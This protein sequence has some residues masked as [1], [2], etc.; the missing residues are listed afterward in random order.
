M[1]IKL[2]NKHIVTLIPF[3]QNMKLRG[4]RSRARSKFLEIAMKSYYSLHES[5]VELLKEYAVLDDSGEPKQSENGFTLKEE[6]AREYLVER[7]KLFS[8]IAEIEGGTYTSHLEL[9]RQILADYDEELDGDNAALYDA[10]WDAFEGVSR[11][12]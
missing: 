6:T 3:L 5:E 9:M 12:G 8:E 11:D 2:Q 7:D 10:L 1:R 4:E